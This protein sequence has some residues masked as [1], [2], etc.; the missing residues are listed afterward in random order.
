MLAEALKNAR[1]YGNAIVTSLGPINNPDMIGEVADLL[2]REDKTTWTMCMG[3]FQ[4]KILL[5]LRT[6]DENNKAETVVKR[7]VARRG[8]GGGHQTYAG[9]QIPL[10]QNTQAELTRM[11][12]QLRQKFVRLI[13]AKENHAVKLIADKNKEKIVT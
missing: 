11:E 13:G 6:I 4:G 7:L 5:S 9:G 3:L 8:T 1:I 10:K 2:L 12:K